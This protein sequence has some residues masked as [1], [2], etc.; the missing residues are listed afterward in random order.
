MA[1]LDYDKE[2]QRFVQMRGQDMTQQT[3]REG[4]RVTMRGQDVSAATSR[5]GQDLVNARARESNAVQQQMGRIPPGYKLSA[6]GQSLEAIP[7]GPAALGKALPTKLVTDLSEQAQIADSTARFKNTFN[8]KFGGHTVMGDLSNVAGRILGDD[9]GQ[10]QWWQDYALHESTIRN[11]LFGASLTPGEQGQW[12]KLTITPRMDAKQIR[13]NL[14]RRAEIEERA[15]ARLTSGSAAAGYN[16]EQI[17]SVTGRPIAPK[18]ATVV[19]PSGLSPAEQA[20]L[21]QLRARFGKK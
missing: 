13:D 12:Q 2:M 3:A 17:E 5:R 10:S 1:L 9:T 7:G 11:K 4:Q 14:Q 6:D 21:D 16:K 20:E 19:K 15:L 8:D 18:A